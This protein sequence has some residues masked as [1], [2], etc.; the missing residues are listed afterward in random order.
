MKELS[1]QCRAA[2]EALLEEQITGSDKERLSTSARSHF[3]VCSACSR[4]YEAVVSAVHPA[5]P[6]RLY[7]P[8]LRQRTLA[9]VEEAR[10]APPRW[11]APLL[12]P[13]AAVSLVLSIAAPVWILSGLFEPFLGSGWTSAGIALAIST[14]TGLVTASLG[15]GLLTH[16]KSREIVASPS[17][18]FLREVNHG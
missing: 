4:F 17:G 9:G 14:S 10:H 2:R 13:A 18:S 16:L 15:L 8:A 5:P 7:T 11:L 3:E 12:V 6:D 1:P